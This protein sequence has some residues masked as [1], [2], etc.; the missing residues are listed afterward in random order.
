MALPPALVSELRATLAAF[1]AAHGAVAVP[2]GAGKALEAWLLMKLAD[3]A[4]RTTNWLVT[5]RAG[6]GSQLAS[7]ADFRLPDQPSPIA[8]SSS[9]APCF[10][11]LEHHQYDDRRL[12]LHGGLQWMGRSG[13][14]HECDISV[15]PASIGEALRNS[16]GG[17]PCGLPIAAIECKDKTSPGTPDEM[18]QT[19][20]R[21]FDLA[22]VTQPTVGPCRI[23]E[24]NTLETW[25]H[26]SSKYVAHFASGAFGIARAGNFQLSA[27]R[28][29]E[30]YHIGRFSAIYDPSS[31]SVSTLLSRFRK[32]LATIG[33]L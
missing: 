17:Y 20:A 4:R 11:L 2:G 31:H 32:V 14:R 10:V 29:G 19:L 22:L 3:T 26:R 23:Y 30:H 7:G 18:R 15:I 9:S 12:E 8:S 16:G 27:R 13:A 21:L 1:R 28:L 5:L 6:D 25:G 33:Y 24:G